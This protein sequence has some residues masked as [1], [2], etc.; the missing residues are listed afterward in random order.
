MVSFLVWLGIVVIIG[1]LLFILVYK[2]IRKVKNNKWLNNQYKIDE[3]FDSGD[4][5]RKEK[6]D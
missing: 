3:D 4:T 1:F 5:Y 6:H 2:T